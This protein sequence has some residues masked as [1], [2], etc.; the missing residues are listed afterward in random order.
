[1][2]LATLATLLPRDRWRIFLVTPSTL[3]RWHRELIRRR[4]TY[5]T[6]GQRRRGLDPGVVSLVLRLARENPLGLVRHATDRRPA[7]VGLALLASTCQ[8]DDVS[9]IKTIGLLDYFG[10]LAVTSLTNVAGTTPDLIWLVERSQRWARIK[11]I[12]ALCQRADPD[13]VGWLLRH[14]VGGEEM[15]ASLARQ[16]ADTVPRTGAPAVF[17]AG[18]ILPRRCWPRSFVDTV[19][20]TGSSRAGVQAGLTSGMSAPQ[21]G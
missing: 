15:S 6:N 3:L 13:A 14:A 19:R 8:P 12:E 9:L 7:M 21:N 18:N 20:P 11:A 5:P 17:D 4:W 1:L 10:P 16:V 2:I